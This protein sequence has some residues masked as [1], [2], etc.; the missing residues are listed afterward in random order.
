M[1]ASKII[2]HLKNIKKKFFFSNLEEFGIIHN[3]KN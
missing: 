3:L 2:S 1:T